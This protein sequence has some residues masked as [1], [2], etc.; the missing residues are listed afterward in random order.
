M[1]RYNAFNPI[2]KALRAMMYDTA[3]TLQHTVF[4]NQD[5]ANQ[6]LE[7]VEQTLQSFHSH[8]GH[9]DGFVL[10]AIEKYAPEVVHEFEGEHHKDEELS[11]NLYSLI[12][13]YRLTSDDEAKNAC[14]YAITMAFNEFIAFNLYH[15]NKEEDKIN[16]VLW[17][18]YTDFELATISKAIVAQ[19]PP[20]KLMKEAVWMMKGM[21]N[22]EITGWLG[23]VKNEAPDP[24]F[25][26][27]LAVAES[28][29]PETRWNLIKEGLMEGA[30]M[31]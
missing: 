24:A 21:N 1:Q 4:S 2:H 23:N 29:L 3:M 25:R 8:A 26:A 30:M 9:E 11:V 19:I 28:T 17:K 5:E 13:A 15:M 7:K 18:N 27:L 20:E 6:A 10:P 14:G 12:A 31:A 22:Q 16:S